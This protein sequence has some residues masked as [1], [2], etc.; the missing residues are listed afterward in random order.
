M[1]YYVTFLHFH[2]YKNIVDDVLKQLSHDN[3]RYFKK[4][5]NEF[6][7]HKVPTANDNP[8]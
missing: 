7:E 2:T 3:K 8:G 6:E 4:R 1:L 5:A